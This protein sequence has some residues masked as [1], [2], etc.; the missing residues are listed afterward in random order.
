LAAKSGYTLNAL[1]ETDGGFATSIDLPSDLPAGEYS[2][3]VGAE[4]E[5][6]R[7]A[8]FSIQ[9]VAT[10][11]SAP[12]HIN[13]LERGAKGDGQFDNSGAFAA[14]FSELAG[15][16]SAVVDIPAG[17]Y[18]FSKPLVLPPGI[19]LKGRSPDDTALFFREAEV[20]PPAWISGSRDFGLE[21]ITVYVG[22]HQAIIS[23][24]MSGDPEKTGHVRLN[25]VRVRGGGFEGGGLKPEEAMSRIAK[26]AKAS[27]GTETVR[28]S[29]PDLEVI[30]CD[31]QGAARVLYL[32]KASGAV[33]RGNVLSNGISGWYSIDC[34]ENVVVEE[35]TIE[36]G[37]LLATGGSYSV[38]GAPRRS[39]NFYTA[40]N[41]YR[42]LSGNNGEAFTSDGCCGVYSGGVLSVEGASLVLREEPSWGGG[43][44]QGA[45][46][47]ITSGRGVGQ[48]RA[49]G[50]GGGRNITLSRAFEIAPDK[51]SVLTIVPLHLHYVFYR[52]TFADTGVS[53]QFYGSGVEHIAAEN[54]SLNGGGFYVV[55]LNYY[56]G[57]Q[58]QV[59]GQLLNN[60]VEG[61]NRRYGPDSRFSFG[62]SYIEADSFSPSLVVGLVVRGNVLLGDCAIRIKSW[63]RAGMKG[64]LVEGNT[65]S[66]APIVD[67]S[68]AAEVVV[69]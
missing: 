48:W 13:A 2:L 42:H 38:F 21:N 27:E 58:P 24:D 62:P 8:P 30:D 64:I 29:G 7:S 63:S 57:V 5:I 15:H 50:S 54:I 69:R 31:L 46:V 43:S 40:R 12:I 67:S 23:S 61:L 44:W 22:R 28:L 20:P 26:L 52:N 6:T 66:F 16:G 33:L 47:A 35:N 53:I 3:T 18:A 51:T 11:S 59:N 10:N 36:G 32:A 25:R 9:I 37:D 1:R 14:I 68:V 60:R 17:S 39:Q 55:A 41:N 65:S 4:A 19:H 56:Q 34:S 49:L 45:L